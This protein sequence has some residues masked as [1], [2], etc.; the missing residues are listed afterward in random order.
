MKWKNNDTQNTSAH[1]LVIRPNRR[2]TTQ[3]CYNSF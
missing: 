3:N 2:E 1:I